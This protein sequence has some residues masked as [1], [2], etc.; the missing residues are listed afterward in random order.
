MTKRAHGEGTIR[1]RASGDWEAR[2]SYVDPATGQRCRLSLYAKTAE[3]VRDKLDEA[4]ERVKEQAPVQDSTMRLADWIEHWSVTSLEASRRKQSTKAL[5]ATLARKHLSP[6]PLGVTSL[7]RLRKTHID[8][9]IV[10]LR[11]QGL[12]DSTVRQVYTVL[13]AALDDAVGDGLIARNPCVLVKRPRVQHTEARHLDAATVATVLNAAVG[14]R[15]H[16][17][18]MLIAATG[19]GRG[20]ALALHWE[21]VN[22]GD[23]ALKVTAT[24]SR[25]GD[26]LVI[27]EPKSL[28]SRRTVPLSPA[29]VSMLK[30]H[31]AAQAAERLHA[32]NQW[33][34]TGLVFTTEFGGPADP[35][36]VLRTI[37]L[38]AAKAGL[39][40]VG[41]HTLRHSAAVAW[42]EAGVHIK[43]VA[44]LLGH[45]SI[46]VT[47]DIYGHT[48]DATTR[49]AIDGLSGA[50]G[51]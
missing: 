8:G 30:A 28:R 49:A 2:L 11:R 3:A 39:E 4:R 20:E 47:G 21:H 10:T 14:L 17:V 45:T 19:L 6:A 41:V 36:N 51:L 12:S 40:N 5:Y 23:G 38:A 16:P 26:Q 48:S 27:T 24:L 35:R 33:T 25:V 1:Q 32:G 37:E 29:V 22:L 44:D 43:A 7:D 34:D 50:L 15:Y 13:R 46:A 18:L 9:L 31:K 42:L